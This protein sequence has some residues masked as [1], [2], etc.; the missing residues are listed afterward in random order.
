MSKLKLSIIKLFV[1]LL[2]SNTAFATSI[3]S[4]EI[5]S[6]PNEKS[7]LLTGNTSGEGMIT[8]K[9][10]SKESEK[11]CTLN[12][13]NEVSFE[14]KYSLK[15]FEQGTYFIEI[16]DE[17]KILTQPFIVNNENIE[18]DADLK[19]FAFKPQLAFDTSNYLF[20]I[21]WLKIGNSNSILTI[22]DEKSNQFFKDKIGNQSLVHQ[23]Y[24]LSKLP[25]GIY[26]IKI[27]DGK[28]T[29]SQSIEMK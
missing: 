3:S 27:T 19:S 9:I 6:T 10:I 21:N 29:Y 28:H 22:E 24:D 2:V 13:K 12:I 4:F 11:V 1:L 5:L 20:E 7:F 16:E 14:Q 15:D 23:Y 25:A 18:V 17:S 26:H 8:I